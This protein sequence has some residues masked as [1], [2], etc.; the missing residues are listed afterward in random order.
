MHHLGIN[1]RLAAAAAAASRA[2]ARKE[3]RF[4][5]EGRGGSYVRL[6]KASEI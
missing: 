2:P 5:S 6:A 4:G 1:M 3:K